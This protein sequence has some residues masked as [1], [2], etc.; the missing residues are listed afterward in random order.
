MEHDVRTSSR[1]DGSREAGSLG[2]ERGNGGVV[3]I[4]RLLHDNRS[5]MERTWENL[6]IAYSRW[7]DMSWYDRIGHT[8]SACVAS[9]CFAGEKDVDGGGSAPMSARPAP[10]VRYE[11]SEYDGT[12]G[13]RLRMT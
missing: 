8:C 4:D 5:W 6:G 7:K 1:P 9:V 12:A 10:I 2:S 3:N 11:E 13:T